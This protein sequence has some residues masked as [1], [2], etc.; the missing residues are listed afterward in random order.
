MIKLSQREKILLQIL[1]SLIVIA[2]IYFLIISPIIEMRRS[3]D[4][5]VKEKLA[6][7]NKIDKIYMEYKEL[8]QKKNEIYSQLN[9]KDN[10]TSQIEQYATSNNIAKNIAYTRRGQ[11]V[12]QNKYIRIT[13]DIKF[14]GVAMDKLLKFIY[15]VENSNS[16][17]KLDYIRI[18]QGLKDTNTYDVI[19]KIDSFALQ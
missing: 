7:V 11:S 17:L 13:T 1:V 18:H 15:D 19:M 5:E 14:D 16:L 6:N 12:I 8:L 4:S 10:L 3:G 2:I 9:K